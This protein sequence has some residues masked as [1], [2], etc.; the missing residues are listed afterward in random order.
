MV[1]FSSISQSTVAAGALVSSPLVI[2]SLINPSSTSATSSFG[3][4]LLNT[5]NQIVEYQGTGLTFTSNQAAS[6]YSLSLI[7]NNTINSALTS[8]SVKFSITATSYQNSSL[9]VMT[10]PTQVNIQSVSCAV[11]SSNL[12]G[13]SCSPNSNRVQA[14]LTF[15]SLSTSQ[16]VEFTISSYNNFPSLEPYTL[17]VDLYADIHQ[18]SKLNTHS[19]TFQN[20]AVGAITI[21]SHSFSNAILSSSTNL[22]FQIS[23]TD[24]LPFSYLVISFPN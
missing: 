1:T 6:F 24:G 11:V 19:A 22:N 13:V 21:S 12:V 14:L 10:F 23:A 8:L 16:A 5:L 15:S 20:T 7:P 9:L 18:N 3:V 2:N 17:Q 4:Y